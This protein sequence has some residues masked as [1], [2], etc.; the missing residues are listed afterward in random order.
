MESRRKTRKDLETF[1]GSR[2]GVSEARNRKRPHSIEMI[3]RLNE[4]LGMPAEVLIK[5]YQLRAA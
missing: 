4:E 3:R 2:S 1:L 5:L